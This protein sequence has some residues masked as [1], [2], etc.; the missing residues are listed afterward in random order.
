MFEG[1]KSNHSD[2]VWLKY[3]VILLL[4]HT[5]SLILVKHFQVV[6]FLEEKA[7]KETDV[8][9]KMAGLYVMVRKMV[10]NGI[11]LSIFDQSL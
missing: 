9:R 4:V 3:S 6:H 7:E 2:T 11:A 10:F 5:L 8:A 1:D